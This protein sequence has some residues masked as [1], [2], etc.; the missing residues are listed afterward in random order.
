MISSSKH[1]S[2]S[3]RAPAARYL[4]QV[5]LKGSMWR[6]PSR[7]AQEMPR[8]ITPGWW[9]S[10]LALPASALQH[11]TATD[12]QPT[13]RLFADL[14]FSVAANP[15]KKGVR[16]VKALGMLLPARS[17]GGKGSAVSCEPASGLHQ[18]VPSLQTWCFAE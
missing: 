15:H 8:G 12:A 17:E 2:S 6:S 5:S 10:V 1:D 3:S 7:H 14:P 13:F 9:E 18:A 4:S 11:K 16:E